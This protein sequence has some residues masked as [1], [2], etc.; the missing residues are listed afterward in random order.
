M[1]LLWVAVVGG[2]G[3]ANGNY[4]EAPEPW[5]SASRPLLYPTVDLINLPGLLVL[6]EAKCYTCS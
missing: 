4:K 6:M 5:V 2:G 1:H 3:A